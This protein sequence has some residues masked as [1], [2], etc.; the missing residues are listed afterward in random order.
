MKVCI[1][2]PI[3]GDV[4]HLF[5][6]ALSSL[7]AQAPVPAIIKLKVGDSLVCRA[8]NSLAADFLETDCTHLLFI[9]SDLGFTPADVTRITSHPEPLVGGLYPLKREGDAI[10]WCGNGTL[11]EEPVREDG[12]Q[13]VR[14]LGTGFLCIARTVLEQ[15]IAADGPD[16]AYLADE[17]HRPEHDF[18]QVG[19]KNTATGRR[20]LSEDWAFC[21]RWLDLGGAVWADTQV[22]LRHHG[23]ITW[24]L[25]HQS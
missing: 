19:V 21:Q 14:Y 13:R 12:L 23:R 16:I 4:P 7:I 3:Y 15:I 6:A 20:Y 2:I 25:A 11:S 17:T 8:R 9:D 24:P 22:R 18:F 5:L 10:Q 1:G